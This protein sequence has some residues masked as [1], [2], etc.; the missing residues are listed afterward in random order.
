MIGVVEES[1]LVRD[2]IWLLFRIG[3]TISTV[4]K[5]G[6]QEHGLDAHGCC[7]DPTEVPRD[8]PGI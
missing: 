4:M 8:F 2:N 1:I 7:A 6:G 3:H 5:Y